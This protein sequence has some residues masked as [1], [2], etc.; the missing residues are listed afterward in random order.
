ML[1]KFSV[2]SGVIYMK[3]SHKSETLVM[4]RN[5][6]LLYIQ[7][8]ENVSV[9]LQLP[10]VLTSITSAVSLNVSILGSVYVGLTGAAR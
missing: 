2:V 10:S 8:P 9:K 5:I 6:I 1:W 3:Y 7:I 4:R